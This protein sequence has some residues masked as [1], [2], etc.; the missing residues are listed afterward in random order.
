MRFKKFTK[1]VL[2]IL[3][4]M[5]AFASPVFAARQTLTAQAP[6]AILAG[7]PSAGSLTLAFTAA[8][9]TNF[10]EVVLT[11]NEMLLVWN[12]GASPYTVTINTTADEKGRV[13]DITAYSLAAGEHALIGPIPVQGFA[14]SNGKLYFQ[15][16]NVAVKYAVIQ[17]RGQLFYK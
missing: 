6:G 11:G 2:T 8:D 15:A 5:L 16:S 7:A 10:E 1:Q 9:T 13:G 12:S 17:P 3:S 4:I 14:Q